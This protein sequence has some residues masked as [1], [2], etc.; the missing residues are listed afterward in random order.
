[1]QLAGGVAAAA[2]HQAGT[3]RH[4]PA[5]NGARSGANDSQE[6]AA[7]R[8]NVPRC[9]PSVAHCLSAGWLS[10]PRLASKTSM[11]TE[12][13]SDDLTVPVTELLTHA[14]TLD[15]GTVT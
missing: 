14:L 6:D 11:V 1:M 9:H 7:P 13:Q 5:H 3:S 8:F 12:H 4:E 15:D 2:A 10:E